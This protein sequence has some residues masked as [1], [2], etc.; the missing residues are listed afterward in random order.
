MVWIRPW[1]HDQTTF[2]YNRYVTSEWYD[3]MVWTMT[4]PFDQTTFLYKKHINYKSLIKSMCYTQQDQ[5]IYYIWVR[6]EISELVDFIWFFLAF[7]WSR[8]EHQ[9]S[10][11]Q[12][13]SYTMYKFI[14]IPSVEILPYGWNIDDFV[15]S[16]WTFF[17]PMKTVEILLNQKVNKINVLRSTEVCPYIVWCHG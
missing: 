10:S 9:K 11:I 4:R 15:H 14:S 2:L 16:I 1:L 7:L 6:S 3:D 17:W 8:T 5:T 12:N 13:R